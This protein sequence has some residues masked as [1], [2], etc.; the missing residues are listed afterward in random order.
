M[1]VAGDGTSIETLGVVTLLWID[2]D[3]VAFMF[4]ADTAG[5]A[6]ARLDA[7]PDD[8][9]MHRF[10]GPGL[11]EFLTPGALQSVFRAFDPVVL[12]AG[13]MVVRE[14]EPADMFYVLANGSALRCDAPNEGLRR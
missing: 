1:L 10:L 14:G 5:Y 7:A 6:V 12:A 11:V 9:W 13:E 8:H 4:G 2:V 3:P